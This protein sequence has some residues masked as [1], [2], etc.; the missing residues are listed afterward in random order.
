MFYPP[1]DHRIHT[2]SSNPTRTTEM[3]LSITCDLLRGNIPDDAKKSFLSSSRHTL[4][5]HRLRGNLQAD[6]DYKGA[7][8]Q[9]SP[10]QYQILIR[11]VWRCEIYIG[12]PIKMP[13][14]RR[15]RSKN[16]Y[17]VHNYNLSCFITAMRGGGA[18]E[19]SCT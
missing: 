10:N 3:L 13:N 15:S 14:I 4:I 7:M 6:L 17:H 11:H 9:K 2:T 16:L 1:Q 18:S 19:R 5:Q 12:S 8:L